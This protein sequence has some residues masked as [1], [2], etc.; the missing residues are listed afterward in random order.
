MMPGVKVRLRYDLYKKLKLIFVNF[1]IKRFKPFKNPY[2]FK[3]YI[4]LK[5]IPF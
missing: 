1:N 4:I 5:S 3:I 2:H